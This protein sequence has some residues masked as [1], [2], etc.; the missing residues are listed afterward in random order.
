M[1]KRFNN[2]SIGSFYTSSFFISAFTDLI[3]RK[4]ILKNR[5]TDEINFIRKE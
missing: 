2:K 1:M 3:Y 5:N 4:V